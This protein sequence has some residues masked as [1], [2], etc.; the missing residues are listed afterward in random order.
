MSPATSSSVL[1]LGTRGSPLAL[2]QTRWVADAL[3][4]HHPRLRTDIVVIKTAGDRN[5]RD[6][7]SRLGGKGLFVKD[8]EDALQRQEIDLA[9]HSMKD[10]PTVLPPGLHLGAIPCRA[11]VRDVFV[12]RDGRRLSEVKEA[13]R[14]GTGSLRRQAQLLALHAGLQVQDV[15]GNVDTRL[16]KLRRGEVDG[17]VLAAIGLIRLGLQE[18]I[19]EYLPCEVMLPAVGQGALA[20]ETRIGSWVDALLAP[21]HH[22]PTGYAIRAERAFLARL[23]GG[24]MVPIAAFGQ[25]QG[26]DLYLQ[27]LVSTPRGE[28]ML[29]QEIR[30]PASAAETLGTRLAEQ[31]LA[32]G[33]RDL[34]P[35]ESGQDA[36]QARDE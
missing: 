18:A 28:R 4:A 14:I 32:S 1:R 20:L 23:G 8:I 13:W 7:L 16:R 11:E 12:S 25:C 6:P 2:W 36:M 5:R 22:L 10:M 29:R 21:L 27:G 31:L 35:L 26:E 30:G 34:L 3:R 9:V 19:S 17:L 24:C 15:R 33:A